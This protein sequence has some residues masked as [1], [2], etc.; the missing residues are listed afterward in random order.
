MKRQNFF[1]NGFLANYYWEVGLLLLLLAHVVCKSEKLGKLKSPIWKSRVVS[2]DRK[3]KII[4]KKYKKL[5]QKLGRSVFLGGQK[6]KNRD[7]VLHCSHYKKNFKNFKIFDLSVE[8]GFIR[9][10]SKNYMKLT[11]KT[12]PKVGA[13]CFFR[14]SK[15]KKMVISIP[16][17]LIIKKIFKKLKIFDLSVASGFIGKSSKNYMKLTWISLPK[18][19]YLVFILYFAK[20]TTFFMYFQFNVISHF[21][22]YLW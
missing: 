14:G 10:I 6:C 2:L 8:T 13:K 3:L 15:V 7:Y 11:C 17:H 18:V 4:Q 5:G 22:I 12:W 19:Y 16:I 1:E 21:E 9:Q 20:N